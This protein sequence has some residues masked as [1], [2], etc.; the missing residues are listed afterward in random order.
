VDLY[1]RI[2][3]QLSVIV[4]KSRLY[5]QLLDERER[6]ERLLLHILPPPVAERLKREEPII[7]DGYADASVLFADL[8]D[9]T[10]WAERTAPSELVRT[11]RA[12]RART[13]AAA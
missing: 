3:S 4:E 13:A 7:A 11:L 10:T 8:V 12:R 9:F 5:E 6:S 1:L 2:A